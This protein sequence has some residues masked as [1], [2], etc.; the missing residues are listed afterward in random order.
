[1]VHKHAGEFVANGTVNQGRSHRRI[2]AAR[3]AEN[4]FFVTDLFANFGHRFFDVI[5]HDPVLAG[6]ANV[7][8]EAVK[9]RLTLHGVRDLR[10][11]LNRIKAADFIGHAGNR[12]SR[13]RGHDLEAFR[14]LGHLVTVA[15]PDFEHA[16]PFGR[17]K[18]F[19][20]LEQFGVSVGANFG[21]AKLARVASFDLATQLLGHGLHAITNAQN[22]NTQLKHGIRCTVID[23]VNTGVRTRQDHALEVAI[24]GIVTHPVTGHITG[25]Y[26][27]K[28]MRF[29][30]SACDQLGDLR[31]E[32]KDQ[33]FGVLHGRHRSLR[34][35]KAS[36]V[37]T[38]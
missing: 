34:N 2:N 15:H 14:Q 5:A 27:A 28:H 31:A 3:Q 30:H 12:A 33:D 18:V 13:S 32:I 9:Q 17:G 16:V 4:D 24:L 25:V 19:N 21:I 7:K 6:F 8:H 10:V 22:R 37:Q 36:G 1:M 38:P 23:F 35:E 20:A 29:A 11:E 26:F